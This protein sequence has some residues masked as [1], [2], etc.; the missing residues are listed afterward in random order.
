[1]ECYID[2]DRVGDV[3]ERKLTTNCIIRVLKNLILWFSRKQN[4]VTR[5]SGHAEYIALVE[6]VPEILFVF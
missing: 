3:A 5:F 1:M 2:A 4:A 6:G